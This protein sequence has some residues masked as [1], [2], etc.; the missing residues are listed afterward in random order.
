MK[1]RQI[2]QDLDDNKLE[3]GRLEQMIKLQQ[4][5]LTDTNEHLETARQRRNFLCVLPTFLP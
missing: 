1:C 5:A 4:D 3:L 2:S